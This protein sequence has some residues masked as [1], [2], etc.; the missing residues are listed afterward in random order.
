MAEILK[1]D[2][3]AY[4]NPELKIQDFQLFLEMNYKRKFAYID[5]PYISVHD[6][7]SNTYDERK[8]VLF[9]FS[10]VRIDVYYL[11][12]YKI[13]QDVVDV[14]MRRRM[15]FFEIRFSEL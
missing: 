12:K 11:D 10:Y 6:P 9:Y 14:W 15:R 4:S 5:L 13:S 3:Y 2:Y 7:I 1:S 8:R